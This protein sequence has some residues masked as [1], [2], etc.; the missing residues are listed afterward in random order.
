MGRH[1]PL[2][3]VARARIWVKV[4]E[5]AAGE[6]GRGGDSR[7]PPAGLIHSQWLLSSRE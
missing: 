7:T 4:L 5:E 6:E 3:L 1:R 2:T